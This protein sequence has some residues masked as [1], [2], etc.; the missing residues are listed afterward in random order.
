MALHDL[1]AQELDV[2]LV[3]MLGPVL[4]ISLPDDVV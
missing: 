4:E 3:D 1:L 2:P